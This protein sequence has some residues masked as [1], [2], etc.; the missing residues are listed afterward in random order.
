MEKNQKNKVIVVRVAEIVRLL[1][2]KLWIMVLAGAIFAAAGYGAGVMTT[3]TPMYSS[4]SKLYVTGVESAVPSTP[5]LNL[6]QQILGSYI[7][8]LKSRP[9]LEQVIEDLNLNMSYMELKGCIS[10]N[11][12][13]GTCMLEI[14]VVF[15]K[16]EWS[17]KIADELVTVSA[18]RASEVMGC[19]APVVYEEAS[20]SSEPYNVNN[21]Y[22]LKFLLIG[23]LA[24]VA[25]AG[26]GILVSYFA[27]TKFDNPNKVTDK[28]QL[29]TLGVIPDASAKNASYEEN[30]YQSF[31]AQLFFAKPEA[32]IVDFVSATDRENKYEFLQKAAD[33]LQK[34]GKKVIF[35]DTNLSNP[36]WGAG[37]KSDT[38][39]KG[40][41]AY[42]NGTAK[43]EEVVVHK[44][45]V[46]SIYCAETA[47]NAVELLDGEAFRELLAKLREKYDYILVDTAPIAYVP[48]A[49]CTAKNADAVVLVLSGKFSRI[50]QAREIMQTMEEREL[51]ILG[52]VLK[53]MNIRKGGKYFCKEFGKYFGVYKK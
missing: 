33:S 50:R 1:I 53:D 44:D 15:P 17:K 38:S 20:V 4:T 46:D 8:I 13:E 29:K 43:L 22:I 31:C 9:V 49:L 21:L 42:L 41:E 45:G 52:V 34:A 12:P 7:E 37:D 3:P 51:S 47:V 35:L 40:L 26:F 11:I 23:G 36:K 48:D 25:L 10:E 6:G 16:P 30:A 24:G 28:L 5:G 19:T 14:N 18:E 39:K 32:K 2:K 27:N